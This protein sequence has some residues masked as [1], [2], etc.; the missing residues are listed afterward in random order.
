MRWT[1]QSR[2]QI[3]NVYP[4]F[5]N[6]QSRLILTEDRSKLYA[7]Q[8]WGRGDQGFSLNNLQNMKK[9]KEIFESTNELN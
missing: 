4:L 6:G 9:R 3:Y 5:K 7:E 1:T 8:W 2:E